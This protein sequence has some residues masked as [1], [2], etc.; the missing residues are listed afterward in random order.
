MYNK[1][2]NIQTYRNNLYTLN[3][4]DLISVFPKQK[5]INNNLSK[6]I[7]TPITFL[8]ANYLS[9]NNNLNQSLFL[10]SDLNN[11]SL[12]QENDIISKNLSTLNN[13]SKT[14]NINNIPFEPSVE[15]YH[16][17][18]QNNTMVEETQILD[19]TQPVI[20]NENIEKNAF[21]DISLTNNQEDIDVL[22][23][24]DGDSDDAKTKINE[25][26]F[27]FSNIYIYFFNG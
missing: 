27:F 15:I 16:L 17:G 2:N 9:Q 10:Q 13:T 3:S 8:S 18:K 12:Y 25:G 26:T 7:Q 19:N 23:E 1:F 24:S 4:V 22:S 21:K 11:K 20:I 5:L 14:F 6:S